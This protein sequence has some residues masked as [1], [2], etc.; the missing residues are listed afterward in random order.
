MKLETHLK[1]LQE[2]QKTVEQFTKVT[3]EASGNYS[4]TAGYLGSV[5]ATT[6]PHL[7]KEQ[8]DKVIKQLSKETVIFTETLSKSNI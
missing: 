3:A 2:A 1:R 8:F 5:L 7:S 6:L 4:Y